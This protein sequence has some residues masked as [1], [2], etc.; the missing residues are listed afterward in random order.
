M[1]KPAI[2]IIAF[3]LLCAC[4]LFLA[5]SFLAPRPSSPL[6]QSQPPANP[7]ATP[8]TLLGNRAALIRH[9][10][11][12]HGFAQCGGV[13]NH[14]ACLSPDGLVTVAFYDDPVTKALINVPLDAA[15]SKPSKYVVSL[16]IQTGL[17]SQ[18]WDWL[19]SQTREAEASRTFGDRRVTSKMDG[20]K[21]LVTVEI[22]R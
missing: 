12:E 18:D 3:L 5:R 4:G 1:K 14:I 9:F 19:V 13:D 10:E 17:K 11:T 15:D 16:L 7:T 21:W 2:W 20:E 8:D 22:M 6:V